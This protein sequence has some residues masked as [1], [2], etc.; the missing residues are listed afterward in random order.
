MSFEERLICL[1]ANVTK[2]KAA[3]LCDS[4]TEICG[5]TKAS[6]FELQME[7]LLNDFYEKIIA[8]NHE[9]K[10]KLIAIIDSELKKQ[11]R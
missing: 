7:S 4:W 10:N 6:A 5:I 8:E 1:A 11:K 9:K 3:E 2:K